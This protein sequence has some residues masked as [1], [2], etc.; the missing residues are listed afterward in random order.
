MNNRRE[1]Y[2]NANLIVKIEAEDFNRLVYF[3]YF[4]YYSSC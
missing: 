2:G 3:D 1:Y 4:K